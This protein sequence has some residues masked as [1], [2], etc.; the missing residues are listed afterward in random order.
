VRQRIDVRARPWSIGPV[1]LGRWW[2]GIAV[3]AVVLVAIDITSRTV[4]IRGRDAVYLVVAALAS[5][6]IVAI[7]AFVRLANAPPELRTLRFL[8]V[9]LPSVFILSIQVIL[10]FLEI[11]ETVSEV[12]EHV[13]ATA[14][15]SAGAIPFSVYVFRSFTRLRDE[16]ADR[17]RNLERLHETSMALSTETAVP[18]LDGRIA[19]GVRTIV[20]AD[21]AVLAHRS[22]RS[23]DCAVATAPSGSVASIEEIDAVRS[24][25]AS[26]TDHATTV[27]LP[28][29]AK[30]LAVPIGRQG[31]MP[32][33]IGA[34]R[35][36]G[37]FSLEDELLLQMYAVAASAALEN[38]TRLEEAQ[39]VAMIDER[40]RIAR[41]LH[42]DLGQ[43]LAFVTAKIQAVR[44]LMT[45]GRLERA[46]DE[47]TSLE[48]ASR[49]LGAQVREAIL[50]LRA[51]TGPDRPLRSALEDYVTD[52]GIQAGLATELDLPAGAGDDLPGAAQYQVLRVA[53]EA[54]SNARRHAA[55]DRVRVRL[56]ECDGH[57]ELCI[58]DDGQGFDPA[59]MGASGGFGLRT[60][61]ERVSALSGT[62]S[63]VSRPGAGTE[64]TVRVPLN[65][66]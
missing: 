62:F 41:D 28:T 34:V 18:R 15:L 29:G 32:A 46:G 52:F 9:L 12:S 54:L 3:W 38:V 59:G 27:A 51:R 48:T 50:G 60:M 57:L 44:E 10:Y 16:L 65:G 19:E 40:E 53:Q 4:G 66:G 63:L 23:D 47:L 33:A 25:A 20:P 1:R 17:A 8:A 5:V 43:L 42:D 2:V 24:A 49:S 37:G 45:A 6:A 55:A 14:V 30:L 26:G 21:R 7:A 36:A 31:G 58:A 35:D 56:A 64:V 11:D 39:L 13:L 22:Q 61:Q